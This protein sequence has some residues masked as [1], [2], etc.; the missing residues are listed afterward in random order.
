MTTLLTYYT[1]IY[2]KWCKIVQTEIVTFTYVLLPAFWKLSQVC[3]VHFCKILNLSLRIFN[4]FDFV[5]PSIL[6]FYLLFF[7]QFSTVVFFPRI[8]P[9]TNCSCLSSMPAPP[10]LLSVSFH[11]ML[12]CICIFCRF[13]LTWSRAWLFLSAQNVR[14]N[15]FMR[16]GYN[17]LLKHILD[18][19]WSF[20]SYILYVWFLKIGMKEYFCHRSL[21]VLHSIKSF[22]KL[23]FENQT[24][25]NI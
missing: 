1:G 24:Y 9:Y 6:Y 5:L 10:S 8:S 14:S 17:V 12:C 16:R 22:I 23:K 21:Y 15:V 20:H 25:F 7:L 3:V 19:K 11:I 4:Y 2:Q 13:L 18:Y